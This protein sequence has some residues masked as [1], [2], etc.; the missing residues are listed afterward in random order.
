MYW[1]T[2]TVLSPCKRWFGD[3]CKKPLTK[4]GQI[5]ENLLITRPDKNVTII[6]LVVYLPGPIPLR[7]KDFVSW[8]DEIPNWMESHKSH[9]PNH[10]TV[11]D[12]CAFSETWKSPWD[13]SALSNPRVAGVALLA[14]HFYWQNP[15]YCWLYD[16]L[17]PNPHCQSCAGVSVFWSR[18]CWNYQNQM[19]VPCIFFRTHARPGPSSLRFLS[20]V[21]QVMGRSIHS[22][23]IVVT[24]WPK[25][26]C[27]SRTN[28][29]HP[30]M[31]INP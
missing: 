31:D 20:N 15:Q 22:T 19:I 14:I 4:A 21:D 8:D 13:D 29:N 26:G 27:E 9:V 16:G 28:Y 10:Q 6:W 7:K 23:W 1:P 18:R 3:P 17:S 5:L 25:N 24:G 11:I 30:T 12:C 2:H